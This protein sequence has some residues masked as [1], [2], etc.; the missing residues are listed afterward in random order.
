MRILTLLAVLFTLVCGLSLSPPVA[1]PAFAQDQPVEIDKR[2]LLVP[3]KNPDGSP[4][5]TSFF[6]DPVQ[7][8]VEK[9]R[10]FYG[11][12]TKALR[13]MV[14][15]GKQAAAVWLMGLSF[16][17][18]IF[19]AAGPG[20]GKAVVS[21]WILANNEDLKRGLVIA[22]LSALIQALTAIIA[23]SALLFVFSGGAMMARTATHWL[24]AASFAMIGAMG[25]YLVWTGL[26]GHSHGHDHSH[27]HHGHDHHDHHANDHHAHAEHKH[28]HDDHGHAHVPDPTQLRGDWSW[29]KAFSLALAVGIRPCTGAILVLI[30]ANTFG[31]YWAGVAA[32]LAMALGVFLTIA[33]IAMLSVFAK[34]IARKLAAHDDRKLEL[35]NK[36]MRIGGGTVIAGMGLILFLGA[37]KNPTGFI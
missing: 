10:A 13:D 33:A 37:L 3:P 27:H 30:A 29:A 4:I 2:K 18:G 14:L 32:T 23:V 34:D 15:G 19:H 24:E 1:A 9:Q 20:H 35:L 28:P 26:K 5:T 6:D 7:W 11:A 17:Y 25:L 22:A 21:S 8:V 16:A 12:M 31:F 36:I